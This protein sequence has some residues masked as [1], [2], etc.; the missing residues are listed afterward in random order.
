MA[1]LFCKQVLE[2]IYLEVIRTLTVLGILSP[3]KGWEYLT[4]EL[5]RKKQG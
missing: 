1:N 2:A 3:K 4:A 5:E